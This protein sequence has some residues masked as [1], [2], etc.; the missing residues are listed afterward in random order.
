MRPLAFGGISRFFKQCSLDDFHEY[1]MLMELYNVKKP[2][3]Q[4]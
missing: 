2:V 3:A 1:K 4:L